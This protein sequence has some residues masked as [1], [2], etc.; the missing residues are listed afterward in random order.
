M[1]ASERPEPGREAILQAL[2]RH[3]VRY[4][5]IGGAAAQA[6]GWPEHTE[7]LD[8]TPERSQRNLARLAAAMEELDAGFRVDERRYPNGYRP[9]GGI[10]ARTFRN[11]ICVAFATRH[12]NFDVVI[13]PDGT[14]GY[15]QIAR[16]ATRERMAGTQIVVP[17]ASAETILHSKTV[18]NRQ[19]DRDTLERMREIL[20]PLSSRP[21][22][23]WSPDTERDPG[24]S[25]DERDR[26]DR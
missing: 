22:E 3:E 17:V 13:L 10:D 23:P 12:G 11:Q 18:A 26:S 19:K 24:R 16:T 25:R 15:E 21:Y 20:D 2:E 9:P 8:V 4:V 7:D 5:V 1:S 14:R 6:R